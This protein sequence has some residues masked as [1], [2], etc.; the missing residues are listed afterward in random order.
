MTELRKEHHTVK[1]V[2][3]AEALK[4]STD[5]KLWDA[6]EEWLDS[7]KSRYYDTLPEPTRD[8][9][10]WPPMT[11]RS[12]MV[13][14]DTNDV[15]LNT[16]QAMKMLA[17]FNGCNM[18]QIAIGDVEIEWDGKYVVPQIQI[19]TRT[20]GDLPIAGGAHFDNPWRTRS[21]VGVNFN[22]LHKAGFVTPK[23]Y[24]NM[25]LMLPKE[26]AAFD[27]DHNPQRRL[28]R[29]G[30][31]TFYEKVTF[32]KRGI[33]AVSFTIHSGYVKY[34]VKCDP[35]AADAD[36]FERMVTK[37]KAGEGELGV[38]IGRENAAALRKEKNETAR[39]KGLE[40][41]KQEKAAAAAAAAAGTTAEFDPT[42]EELFR[43]FMQMM[44]AT[45]KASSSSS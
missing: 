22:T 30:L 29:V 15:T 2:K 14:E 3:M 8:L 7:P 34:V 20:H 17:R 41:Q 27:L 28:K 5:T 1:M 33:V 26:F 32:D 21:L 39:R 11:F 18:T 12:W 44:A 19:E 25:L 4:T 6:F 38:L 16:N 43:L 35:T 37:L 9:T 45:K 36:D 10:L 31:S 23:S 42:T 40:K 24:E 13:F